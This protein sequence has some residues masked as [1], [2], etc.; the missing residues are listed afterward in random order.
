MSCVIR[1]PVPGPLAGD[2]PTLTLLIAQQQWLGKQ[3][4]GC[5]FYK[6]ATG[7]ESQTQSR[8][9]VQE[10]PTQWP[11]TMRFPSMG[12]ERWS[13][14]EGERRSLSASSAEAA[15]AVDAASRASTDGATRSGRLARS[16][17]FVRFDLDHVYTNWPSA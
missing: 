6:T 12:S 4:K 7:A 3:K 5:L 17:S 11:V 2:S 10:A 1:R 14:D 16:G 13:L 8:C 15:A 9:G